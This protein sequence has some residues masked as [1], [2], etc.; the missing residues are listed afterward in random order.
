MPARPAL[1]ASTSPSVRSESERNPCLRRCEEC[2]RISA[3]RSS[4]M[5]DRPKRSRTSPMDLPCR[6]AVLRVSISSSSDATDCRV[7]TTAGSKSTEP[8]GN[9]LAM[10]LSATSPGTFA[11]EIRPRSSGSTSKSMVMMREYHAQCHD[12]AGWVI[13]PSERLFRRVQY[14]RSRAVQSVGRGGTTAREP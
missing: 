1:S 14:C 12:C 4:V 10:Y 5:S 9:G 3:I 7:N 13:A 11:S 2:S 8:P 6:V